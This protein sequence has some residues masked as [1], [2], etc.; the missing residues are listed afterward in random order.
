M[1]KNTIVTKRS[2]K[3]RT[4]VAEQNKKTGET[5]IVFR[6]GG[7][8]IQRDSIQAHQERFHNE[9]REELEARQSDTTNIVD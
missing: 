7:V 8:V 1:A 4:V 3:L 6:E 9:Y 2:K 5:D